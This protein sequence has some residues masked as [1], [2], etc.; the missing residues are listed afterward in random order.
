VNPRRSAVAFADLKE[1]EV[2]SSAPSSVTYRGVLGRRTKTDTRPLFKQAKRPINRLMHVPHW[3]ASITVR[4]LRN[5]VV[6]QFRISFDVVGD[7]G[8]CRRII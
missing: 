1:R 3:N 4:P 8:P 7:Y 6:L 5:Q 2:N